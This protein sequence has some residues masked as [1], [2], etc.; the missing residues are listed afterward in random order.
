SLEEALKGRQE[1]LERQ[2]EVPAASTLLPL[3]R[4]ALRLQGSIPDCPPCPTSPWVV[5]AKVSFD[6]SGVIKSIDNCEC[7]RLVVSFGTFWWRCLEPCHTKDTEASPIREQ[8][9]SQPLEP[10]QAA[11]GPSGEMIERVARKR[12]PGR[13]RRKRPR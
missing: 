4:L 11:V 3:S 12:R 6:Q 9:E 1:A 5:L 13:K 8:Q 7:R 2:R 10:S